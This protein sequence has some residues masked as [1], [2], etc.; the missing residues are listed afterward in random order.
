MEKNPERRADDPRRPRSSEAG[1]K[2][3]PAPLVVLPFRGAIRQVVRHAGSN[4]TGA[5]G[6]EVTWIVRGPGRRFHSGPQVTLAR[7]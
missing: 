4:G 6:E 3:G 1:S 7:N 2:D 5:S